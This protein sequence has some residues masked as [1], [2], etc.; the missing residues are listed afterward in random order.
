M[1]WLLTP[2]VPLSVPFSPSF[3]TIS[4]LSTS[5]FGFRVCSEKMIYLKKS[6]WVFKTRCLALLNP[7]AWTEWVTSASTTQKNQFQKSHCTWS[8]KVK[9][10]YHGIMLI[11]YD[12]RKN[13]YNK[14]GKSPFFV[15]DSRSDLWQELILLLLL[16]AWLCYM[17]GGVLLYDSLE[18][19]LILLDG[20]GL[21][22]CYR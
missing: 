14:L 1:P 18:G 5:T 17:V 8:V 20:P 22:Y 3:I 9:Q 4:L 7:I 10:R 21:F 16:D 15:S 12:L 2:L 19:Y 6:F 11:Y 13:I